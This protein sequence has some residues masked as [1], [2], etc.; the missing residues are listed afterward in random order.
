METF[1]NVNDSLNVKQKNAAINE[2]HETEK[3]M[4]TSLLVVK[5]LLGISVPLIIYSFYKNEK[6]IVDVL[7]KANFVCSLFH[8]INWTAMN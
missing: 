3:G 6:L 1:V 7:T 5:I 2:I 4:S 8:P